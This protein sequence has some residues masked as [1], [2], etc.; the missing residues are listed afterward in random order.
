MAVGAIVEIVPSWELENLVLVLS[1]V[2]YVTLW[3]T[4]HLP[5]SFFKFEMETKNIYSIQFNSQN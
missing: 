1:L 2:Y 5:G 4:Q 3:N